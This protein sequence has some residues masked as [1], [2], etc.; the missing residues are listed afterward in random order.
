MVGE[1][2]ADW[3]SLCMLLTFS[4]TGSDKVWPMIAAVTDKLREDSVQDGTHI[5]VSV[6]IEWVPGVQ[7]TLGGRGKESGSRN[8]REDG[9][10]EEGKGRMKREVPAE[11]CSGRRRRSAAP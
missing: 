8:E 5:P 10:W 9:E 4:T 6:R 7:Q 1:R 3:R 11:S 2:A